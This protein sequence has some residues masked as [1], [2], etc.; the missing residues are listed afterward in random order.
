MSIFLALS[1]MG[2]RQPR[3]ERCLVGLWKLSMTWN[4]A[5]RASVRAARLRAIAMPSACNSACTRGAP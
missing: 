1:A 4:A 2:G 3:A 5:M